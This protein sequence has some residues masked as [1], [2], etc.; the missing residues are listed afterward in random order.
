M[1]EGKFKAGYWYNT[2]TGLWTISNQWKE[3]FEKSVYT[4]YWPE[5]NIFDP[6]GEPEVDNDWVL[7]VEFE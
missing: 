1:F 6:P 7:I 2:R 5:N 4:S 3:Q